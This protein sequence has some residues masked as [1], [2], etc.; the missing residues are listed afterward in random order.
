MRMHKLFST[1]VLKTTCI[2]FSFKKIFEIIIYNYWL[3]TRALLY[4]CHLFHT[5]SALHLPISITLALKLSSPIDYE[6][7]KLSLLYIVHSPPE[8][9]HR[10]PDLNGRVNNNNVFAEIR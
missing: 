2:A 1:L 7:P 10:Q 8:Q 6:I 9:T 3:G 5:L 4:L